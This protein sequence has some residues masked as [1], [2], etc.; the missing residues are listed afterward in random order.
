MAGGRT[1]VSAEDV[2]RFKA[3]IEPLAAGDRLGPLLAQFPASFKDSPE[4]RA[5]L[6]WLLRTFSGYEVAVELRHRSWSDSVAST[7]TLLNEHR[8]AWVQIDE[9]KFSFSIRQN[10]LPNVKGFYYMRLHG[11]NVEKWWRHEQ[12]EDR[13]DYLYSG[14]ELRTFSETAVAARMLVKKLYLYMNNHFASKSVANAL[15]IKHQTGEPITGEYSASFLARYPELREFVPT[16]RP[17]P[18]LLSS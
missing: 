12:A 1:A 9:P 18:S 8:A 6:D 10:Y 4:S 15:M 2:D 5:Y 17:A 3:G 11:R 16:S 13:Y 7:L 14:D